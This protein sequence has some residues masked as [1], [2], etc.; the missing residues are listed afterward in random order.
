ML[1]P[2]SSTIS[3]VAM[4]E[5][6][7]VAFRPGASAQAG[8]QDFEDRF[9]AFDPSRPSKPARPRN[10]SCSECGA[11][12]TPNWR[13][14]PD[15][16]MLCNRLGCDA[17]FKSSNSHLRSRCGLRGVRVRCRKPR[18]PPPSRI[19]GSDAAK[20]TVPCVISTAVGDLIDVPS[21]ED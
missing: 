17:L 6:Q 11:S 7:V 19:I 12:E 18:S 21:S 14:G 15:R 5:F 9:V 3:I 20:S 2:G 16:A 13:R 8:S 1:L 10:R 4:N